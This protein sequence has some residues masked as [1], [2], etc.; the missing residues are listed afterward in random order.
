M[1]RERHMF[2]HFI[3]FL[4]VSDKWSRS[5]NPC[6]NQQRGPFR[7]VSLLTGPERN[8][9]FVFKSRAENRDPVSV[10]L[11]GLQDFFL[12]QTRRTLCDDK[13]MSPAKGQGE[14]PQAPER[15]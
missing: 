5:R 8:W 14:V 1:I 9:P 11:A 4:E 10:G 15:H 2:F 12:G 13:A 3:V 7:Q 6:H